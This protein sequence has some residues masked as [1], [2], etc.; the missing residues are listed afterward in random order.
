MVSACSKLV[1]DVPPY[2]LAD[3]SPAE[4]RSINKVGMERTG[5]SKSEIDIAKGVFKTLF[6]GDY[7]RRQAIEHLQNGSKIAAEKITMEIVE[8]TQLSERGL[9]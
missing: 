5:F 8:F 9:A 7:N 4:I 6:R 1:Q 2:M 3:G